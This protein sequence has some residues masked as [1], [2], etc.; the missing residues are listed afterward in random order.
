VPN[1]GQV[2]HGAGAVDF[3]FVHQEGVKA[4][5]DGTVF[6]RRDLYCGGWT[7]EVDHVISGYTTRRSR[8]LH[9]IPNPPV[10]EGQQVAQ[11]QVIG[12]ADNSGSEDNYT[13]PGNQ[14]CSSGSHLHFDLQQGGTSISWGSAGVNDPTADVTGDTGLSLN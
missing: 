8:Y 6:R 11:G 10:A 4:I 12:Y 1:Y 13:Y 7:V 5:G 3:V 14:L 9:L 2:C